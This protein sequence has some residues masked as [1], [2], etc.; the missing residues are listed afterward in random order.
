L[1]AHQ[2]TLSALYTTSLSDATMCRR[3]MLRYACCSLL[4]ISTKLSM[5]TT[6]MSLKQ[7][8]LNVCRMQ[9]NRSCSWQ[10]FTGHRHERRTSN[11][12]HA[13]TNRAGPTQLDGPIALLHHFANLS[14]ARTLER[15]PIWNSFPQRPDPTFAQQ[16]RLP[17]YAYLGLCAP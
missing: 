1:V 9:H 7:G 11:S 4:V 3:L 8:A 12:W 13:S 10:T 6:T 2:P 15:R 17:L 14:E 5:T 16:F